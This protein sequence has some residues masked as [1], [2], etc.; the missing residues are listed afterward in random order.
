[1]IYKVTSHGRIGLTQGMKV[2]PDNG[3]AHNLGLTCACGNLEAV[4]RQRSSSGS[5]PRAAVSLLMPP[6]SSVTRERVSSLTH[7]QIDQGFDG[8][9]LTEVIAERIGFTIA[10]DNDMIAME[11]VIQKLPSS[12]RC[13]DVVR[14]TPF[15]D[16]PA[17]ACAMTILLGRRP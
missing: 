6:N 13:T 4:A 12:V 8:F 3:K 11:P 5:I 14:F 2:A 10:I 9:A 15:T 7:T 1:M 17:E 16:S